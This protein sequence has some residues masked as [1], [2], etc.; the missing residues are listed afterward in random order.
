MLLDEEANGFVDGLVDLVFLEGVAGFGFLSFSGDGEG[1]GA[2]EERRENESEDAHG[3]SSTNEE[4]EV[5]RR[6][7]LLFL[8]SGFFRDCSEVGLDALAI[9]A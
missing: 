6:V 9:F 4:E 1:E 3:R 8:L 5:R 2:R 7:T